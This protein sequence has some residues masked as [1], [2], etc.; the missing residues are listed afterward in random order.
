[1]MQMS[2]TEMKRRQAER[3]KSFR[4]L[5]KE[6]EEASRREARKSLVRAGLIDGDGR[7]TRMYR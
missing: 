5:S 6:D 7:P 3:I 2:V 4:L 1:M